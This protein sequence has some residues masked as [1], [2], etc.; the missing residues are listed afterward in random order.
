MYYMFYGATNFDSK[1]C[2]WNLDEKDKSQMFTGS[3]CSEAKCVTC[4]E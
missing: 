1:M 2:D 3:S 4:P